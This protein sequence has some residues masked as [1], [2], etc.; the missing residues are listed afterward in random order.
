MLTICP[1]LDT[2]CYTLAGLAN[3][4]TGWGRKDETWNALETISGL[5]GPAWFH[6]GDKDIGWHLLRTRMLQDGMTLSEVTSYFCKHHNIPY[7]VYPV[8]NDPVPTLVKTNDDKV[9]NFQDYFVRLGCRP[10]VAGFDFHNIEKSQPVPGVLDAIHDADIVVIGPSNPWVSIQP[11]L[12]VP[13][14]RKAIREKIT[15]VISPVKGDKAFRGPAAKMYL[16]MGINPSAAAV[17]YHYKHIAT[18]IVIDK[19]D[20]DQMAAIEGWGIMVVSTD[21]TMRDEKDRARLASE[22]IKFYKQIE[23]EKF[24]D[25]LGNN[26]SK[27]T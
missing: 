26:S 18:G 25:P 27:T 14:I 16:E 24:N 20:C 19:E 13:G 11:I 6:L 23:Q 15:I 21:I 10:A 17:A 2:V 5:G 12:N 1:D 4:G 8:T 3:S 7:Q 9:L 22:V